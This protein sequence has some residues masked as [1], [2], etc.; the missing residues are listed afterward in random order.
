MIGSYWILVEYL[1]SFV[2]YWLYAVKLLWD[3]MLNVI[4]YVTHPWC[5]LFCFLFS[6][7]LSLCSHI[8]LFML[9]VFS[10][11]AR[12]LTALQQEKLLEE[13]IHELQTQ[14]V[15]S[16]HNNR[17]LKQK[18]DLAL[19]DCKHTEKLLKVAEDEAAKSSDKIQILEMQVKEIEAQNR[20]FKVKKESS[21]ADIIHETGAGGKDQ[22]GKVEWQTSQSRFKYYSPHVHGRNSSLPKLSIHRIENPAFANDRGVALA[23]S[24][25]SASLALLVGIIAW[26]AQEPCM[27]L[28]IASFIVVCM[29]INNVAHFFAS[30]DNRPG[31]D[32]VA[33]LSFNWFILGTL[34][35]PALPNVA[36]FISPIVTR[37]SYWLFDPSY[38]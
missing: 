12:L 33:L 29:S 36:Q 10:T 22:N 5:R 9:K 15:E 19:K 24:L 11:P 26:E 37:F 13:Q 6:F 4:A 17:E 23:S 30:V 34:A 38:E 28:V 20:A 25:F 14:L 18:L 32:A 1:I 7:Y 16:M 31:F 21:F 27:P 8:Y 3:T 35:S 2:Y